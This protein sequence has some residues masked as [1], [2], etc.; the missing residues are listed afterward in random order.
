MQ[1]PE[2]IDII[3]TLIARKKKK[4]C[5]LV[6]SLVITLYIFSSYLQF[7]LDKLQSFLS[8]LFVDRRR[9]PWIWLGDATRDDETEPLLRN[10][11]DTS[12]VPE[13]HVNVQH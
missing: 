3:W 6:H 2:V 1:S 8:F 4:K 7:L 5:Q 13:K 12:P 11:V 10:N 9:R